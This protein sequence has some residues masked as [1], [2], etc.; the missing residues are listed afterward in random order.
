M[1]DSSSRTGGLGNILFPKFLLI[2]FWL[3]AIV[4]VFDANQGVNGLDLPNERSVGPALRLVLPQGWGFFTKSPRDEEFYVFSSRQ[5]ELKNVFQGPAAR[6]KY[7]L[8]LNRHPRAQ[9]IEFGLVLEDS[10]DVPWLKCMGEI[11]QCMERLRQSPLTKVKSRV[12]N[13]T[14]CGEIVLKMQSHVPWAWRHQG[15][16]VV[17]APYRV[18]Y[19]YV[20]C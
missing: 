17:E 15:L 4:Y 13:P 10:K 20:E 19:L 18:K 7:A 2:V 6:V 9:G 16:S 14:F 5:G 12:Q 11:E 3:G 8:G 1:S